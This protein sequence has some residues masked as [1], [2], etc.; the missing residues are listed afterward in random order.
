MW[1]R[2]HGSTEPTAQ[3][4][5]GLTLIWAWRIRR[6]LTTCANRLSLTI[7]ELLQKEGAKVSYNDPFF[8]YVGGPQIQPGDE[9]HAAGKP[10][11]I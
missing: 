5:N 4:P 7:I 3:E 8:E 6:T 11:P 9:K 2:N 1:W 10:A